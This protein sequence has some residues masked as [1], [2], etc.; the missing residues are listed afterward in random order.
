MAQKQVMDMRSNTTGISTAESNEQ[1]RKWD[2]GMWEKKGRDSLANYDPTRRHLNFEIAKGGIVQ[3]IDSSK[4]IMQKMA[5]SLSARGIK[6]PN[7]RENVRRQNR[8][9]AQFI[10]SG[11][12]DRMV[13]LAFGRQP[14]DLKKGAD[15]SSLVR[16]KDIENW[17]KDVYSFMARKFGEDNIISFYVHLDERSP[18]CHC[19]VVPV[20]Q[21]NRISWKNVFGDGRQEES[22]NMTRLHDELEMEVSRKWGLD[23]G[24]NMAE[25][26]AKHRST[27]EYKRD[28]VNEVDSLQH[29]VSGLKQQI[30]RSE[31]KLKGI[32]TKIENLLSRKEEIEKEI[33]NLARQFGE[34]GVDNSEIVLRI[35]N[36]R[37]EKEDIDAT[38]QKRYRQL[39]DA[40]SAITSAKSELADLETKKQEL[41]DVV[42]DKLG[43]K[44]AIVESGVVSAYNR[45]MVDSFLSASQQLPPESISAFDGSGLMSLA[46]NMDD[47]INCAMMLA[48]EYVDDA[49]TYAESCGGGGGGNMTGW[50]RDD[51]DDDERWWLKCVTK[52]AAMMK[53]TAR[54]VGRRR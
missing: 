2:K 29:T 39:E 32:S 17:A 21:N 31:I 28:L 45:M 14:L 43:Q 50:R 6:D 5:E 20:D 7:A 23:R 9:I 3:K 54:S 27:E 36:L 51:D 4:T 53:P 16:E 40:K 26:K 1:Q 49:T 13:E 12:H 41:R 18:H 22:E 33:E 11:S 19:T 8:T 42:S 52:A 15:N 48:V 34:D 38:L 25:V 37:K 30:H 47:I 44:A 10:L 46:E 35:R 24:G